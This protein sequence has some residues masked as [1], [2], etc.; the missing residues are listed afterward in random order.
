MFFPLERR[1]S[2][3]LGVH[4]TSSNRHPVWDNVIGTDLLLSRYVARL[5]QRSESPFFPL[6]PHSAPFWLLI[7][8]P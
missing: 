6:D 1:A 3:S 8:V 4:W 2:L 5:M 7:L